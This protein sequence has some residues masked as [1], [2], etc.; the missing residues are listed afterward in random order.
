MTP[1]AAKKPKGLSIIGL[2]RPHWKALSLALLAVAGEAATDLLDP[3]PLK[4]VLDYLLQSKHPPGWM[5]A[6]DRLDRAGQAGRPQLRGAGG[7]G[8]RRRRRTQLLPGEIPHHQ[9][10]PVGHARP[11]AHALS[12]HPPPVA[13]RARREEDRRPHRPGDERHRSHSELYHHGAVGHFNQCPHPAGDHR[14]HV[15]PELAFLAH[16]AL[17]CAR[18]LPGSLLLH[19]AHQ[20]SL[21]RRKKERERAAFDC[22]RSFL[23]D[24]RGQGLCPRGLRGA[25]LRAPEPGECR[26]GPAGAK[27][28]DEALTYRRYYRSDRD[29]LGARL[30]RAPGTGGPTHRWRAGRFF[31]LPGQ[32]V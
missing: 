25:P 19:P 15:L 21:A 31:A 26:D 18:A 23:L 7:G 14:G 30:W 20:K 9:R 24:P 4:I 6:I 28:Q 22:R 10:R 1:P 12:P 32:D 8:H 29:L 2:L 17:C 13:G 27:H 11:A 5:G 3:W 16:L